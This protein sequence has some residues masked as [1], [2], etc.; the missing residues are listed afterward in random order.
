MGAAMGQ[1]NFVSNQSAANDGAR[2]AA[3][4]GGGAGSG[5]T[6]VAPITNNKTTQNAVVQ[7]PVR[8]QEQTMSRY[9]RSRFAT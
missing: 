5:N 7:L 3:V 9:I 2:T 4:A 1:A 6:V 8:N